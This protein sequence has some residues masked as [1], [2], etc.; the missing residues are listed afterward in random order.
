MTTVPTTE[1]KTGWIRRLG[2]A[3][4]RHPVLVVLSLVAAIISVGFQAVS[5]LL[6]KVAVDDAVGGQ[7]A[8]LGLLAGGLVAVQ[9]LMFATAFVRRYVGGRLALDVQHDLRRDRKSVV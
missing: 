4:W 3:C 6:V 5:P 1:P 7:T 9:V 2:A 8:Q